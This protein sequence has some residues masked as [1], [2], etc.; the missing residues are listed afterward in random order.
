MSEQGSKKYIMGWLKLRPGKRGEF[1]EV[2]QRG[3]EATR[4][5]AGCVFYDYGLSNTDPDSMIIMECF[6]NDGAHAAHLK[7]PHFKA[8][9]A[10]VE[11]LCLEGKFEDVWSD[12]A[13]LS[14]VRF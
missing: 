6:A 12:N 5:E 4:R 14:S 3:A 9:W 7:T 8:V 11:R 13:K 1:V 2:Y 10:A